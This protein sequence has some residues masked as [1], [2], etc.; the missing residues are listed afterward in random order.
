MRVRRTV[1]IQARMWVAVP[2]LRP[3]GFVVPGNEVLTSTCVSERALRGIVGKLGGVGS[4]IHVLLKNSRKII[5]I[6]RQVE[7]FEGAAV[8]GFR[9]QS[10]SLPGAPGQRR[11]GDPGSGLARGF[12]LVPG[13]TRCHPAQRLVPLTTRPSQPDFLSEG[14]TVGTLILVQS[15]FPAEVSVERRWPSVRDAQSSREPGCQLAPLCGTSK[16]RLREGGPPA[17]PHMPG[18]LCE[19]APA[20]G[21]SD[22]RPV[23]DPGRL[24]PSHCPSPPS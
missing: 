19:P 16:Q 18:R 7:P 15:P 2:A 22:S 24:C 6:A 14:H 17:G 20:S 9:S 10:Q 1:C 4:G 23:T 21:A 5:T 8:W 11:W 13:G 12:L 3:A